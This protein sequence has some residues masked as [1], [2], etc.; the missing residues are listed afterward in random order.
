MPI[1]Q[2]VSQEE[3]KKSR[4]EIKKLIEECTFGFLFFKK[5]YYDMFSSELYRKIRGYFPQNLQNIDL[6]QT[7]ERLAKKVEDL[8]NWAKNNGIKITADSQIGRVLSYYVLAASNYSEGKNDIAQDIEKKADNIAAPLT[9]TGTKKIELAMQRTG[10]L[11][12]KYYV[13]N[14]ETRNIKVKGLGEI[15][16]L[17]EKGEY[18]LEVPRNKYGEVVVYQHLTEEQAKEYRQQ[19]PS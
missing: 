3:I 18:G 14:P 17:A 8:I 4:E 19:V 11:G 10:Y 6:H 9:R 12:G 5:L 16:K 13:Y 15:E 2:S 1:E 7:F